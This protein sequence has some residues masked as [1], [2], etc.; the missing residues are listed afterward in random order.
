M[1]QAHI[2]LWW[3]VIGSSWGGAKEQCIVSLIMTSFVSACLDPSKP[4]SSGE[5]MISLYNCHMEHSSKSFFTL[6]F[7]PDSAS[8]I[9]KVSRAIGESRTFKIFIIH[10]TNFYLNAVLTVFVR[11]MHGLRDHFTSL[12][13]T[14]A[15]KCPRF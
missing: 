7:T 4:Q 15:I 10:W 11:I 8:V 14:W 2:I 3:Y 5:A 13:W 12:L 1:A 6:C 9:S